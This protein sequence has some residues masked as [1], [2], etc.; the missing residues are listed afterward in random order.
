MAPNYIIIALYCYFCS[1][2]EI[3]LNVPFFVTNSIF[4]IFFL[5]RTINIYIVLRYHYSEY[6]LP[7]SHIFIYHLYNRNNIFINVNLLYVVF[8]FF[9]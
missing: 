6:D 3:L 9:F 2:L 8:L 5:I 4:T 1:A 7:L